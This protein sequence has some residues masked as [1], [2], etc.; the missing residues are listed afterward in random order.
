VSVKEAVH[1]SRFYQI[2]ALMFFGIFYGLYLASVFKIIAQDF[3][4][5]DILMVAGALGSI[6]TGCS[7]ILWA[8]VMDKFGFKKVY[9]AV[10]VC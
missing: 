4:K 6:C 3:L 7:R 1:N 10:M 9:G 8:S 2:G 5:D